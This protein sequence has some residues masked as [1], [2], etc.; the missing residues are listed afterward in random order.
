MANASGLASA[1]IRTFSVRSLEL[2]RPRS[3][4]QIG[5][6]Q[7]PKSNILAFEDLA[8]DPVR[9][10]RHS[11]QRMEI[12]WESSWECSA[13]MGI[14]PGSPGAYASVRLL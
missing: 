13:T 5:G 6:A 4:V 7:R 3:L 10:R 14:G 2:Q 1:A 9:R 12:R 11:F 8:V